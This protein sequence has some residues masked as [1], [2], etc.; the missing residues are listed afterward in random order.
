MILIVEH[1]RRNTELVTGFLTDNGFEVIS[2]STMEELD[3][4][5]EDPG[6]IKLA[7]IDLAG[8]DLHIWE[9]SELLRREHIPFLIISAQKSPGRNISS[10]GK[11]EHAVLLKPLVVKELLALVNSILR[12]DIRE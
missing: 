7:L 6:S 11:G 12:E 5:L 2:A 4:H 10:L 8:F 9:R 1:N 3:K